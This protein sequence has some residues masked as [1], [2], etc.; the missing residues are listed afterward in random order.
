MKVKIRKDLI[1]QNLSVPTSSGGYLSED[2][3][4]PAKWIEDR[5]WV[6]DGVQWVEVESIDWDFE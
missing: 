4:Y 6:Y 3:E 5:L 2:K 1:E